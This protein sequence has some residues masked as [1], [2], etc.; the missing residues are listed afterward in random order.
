VL[1]PRSLSPEILDQIR[2]ATK[3][4][5]REL[6]VKGLMNIQYAVKDG[7]LYIIEVNPR[8]SRT[9][10]FVSKATG[11]PLAKVATKVMLGRSLK[12]LGVTEEVVINH[13]AVKEAVFPFNRFPGVDPLLGPELKSTGEV[14]GIDADFGAAY[15]KSQYAA[16]QKLP[17]SG[18]VFV[19]VS[20]HD[21]QSIVE[22]AARLSKAGFEI[23]ATSGTA[24]F[25]SEKGIPAKTIRKVSEGR[26]HAV[27]AIKNGEVA[28]LINTSTGSRAAKDGYAIRRAALLHGVPYVTTVAGA[29]ATCAAILAV[30]EKALDV[31]ALQDYYK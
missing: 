1:P 3:A 22:V 21:K 31:C 20:N 12:D 26:P 8:A 14:M 4:L 10:P 27:D 2:A 11:V 19:S 6:G 15:A 13:V 24:A 17:L 7:L 30:Q 16:G 28:L 25:L 29:K 23:I 9:V 5:A 18:S